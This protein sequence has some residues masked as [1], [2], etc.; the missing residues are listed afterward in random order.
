MVDEE[1][2]INVFKNY[3]K[4]SKNEHLEIKISEHAFLALT[5]FKD[6]SNNKIWIRGIIKHVPKLAFYYAIYS[7]KDW[8]KIFNDNG[9]SEEEVDIAIQKFCIEYI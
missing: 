5:Y 3:I 7:L 6:E 2:L 9:I 4:Y 1:M 8:Y